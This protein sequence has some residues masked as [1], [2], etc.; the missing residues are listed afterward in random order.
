ST[1]ITDQFPYEI[2]KEALAIVLDYDRSSSNWEERLPELFSDIHPGIRYMSA[3]ALE[4][5]NSGTRND[6]AEQFMMEEYD[7]RVRR[8]LESAMN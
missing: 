2:R 4:Y 8:V 1:F 6:L 7:E 3:S 5:V